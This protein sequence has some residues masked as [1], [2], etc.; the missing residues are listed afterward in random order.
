M[1]GGLRGSHVI[2]EA[3][4]H[5]ASALQAPLQAID[6]TL[7]LIG[8]LLRLLDLSA[9]N[10]VVSR[11]PQQRPWS[12]VL[13]EEDL[14][15]AK[16]VLSATPS[17]RDQ[18]LGSNATAHHAAMMPSPTRWSNRI[19]PD[20]FLQSGH[21]PQANE[22]RGITRRTYPCAPVCSITMKA[23]RTRGL[24]TCAFSGPFLSALLPE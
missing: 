21:H 8:C 7:D 14:P 12:M 24:R 17:R 2:R 10:S 3:L 11:P 19:G 13:L 22:Q 4:C 16:E 5:V 1:I 18:L 15:P 20:E 6:Q 9:A 23:E